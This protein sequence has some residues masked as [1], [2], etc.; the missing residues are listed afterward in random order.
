MAIPYCA[1]DGIRVEQDPVSTNRQGD[2]C[3][4]SAE[5][6]ISYLQMAHAI[7]NS[8]KRTCTQCWITIPVTL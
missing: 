8:K 4:I 1:L 7:A 6:T 2:P 5:F 3:I